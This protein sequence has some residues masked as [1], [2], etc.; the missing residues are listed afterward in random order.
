MKFL[1]PVLVI[2]VLFSVVCNFHFHFRE[3][4]KIDQTTYGLWSA[5]HSAV[6]SLDTALIRYEQGEH[7]W[8]M[9]DF[10]GLHRE[11]LNVHVI[12]I[13]FNQSFS[14]QF[15]V[16]FA[17]FNFLAQIISPQ[18]I[19]GWTDISFDPVLLDGELSEAELLFLQRLRDDLMV[20][21]GHF[22]RE[23]ASGATARQGMSEREI[24][25][26]MGEFLDNW[27]W[28]LRNEYNW[29]S[30]FLLLE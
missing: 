2:L 9:Q 1:V 29:D 13:S 3:R 11:L 4:D 20:L 7:Q 19:G 15:F 21:S 16:H 18:P 24:R 12:L 25:E 22:S 10:E 23:T 28:H 5:L 6:V 14:N 26:L 27:N 8:A 30:P 17:D